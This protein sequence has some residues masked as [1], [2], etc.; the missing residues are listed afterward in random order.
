MLPKAAAYYAGRTTVVASARAAAAL[1]AL[2]RQQ[3]HTAILLIFRW[4]NQGTIIRGT[5]PYSSY[6]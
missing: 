6:R 2:A 5:F 3:P 1:A 4:L